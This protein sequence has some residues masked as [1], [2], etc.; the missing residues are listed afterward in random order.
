MLAGE[1]F[2]REGNGFGAKT[3][4][5]SSSHGERVDRNAELLRLPCRARDRTQIFVTIGNKRQPVNFIR[6]H[7]RDGIADCAF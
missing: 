4:L 3:R 1:D 6:R 2:R 5:W 7:L